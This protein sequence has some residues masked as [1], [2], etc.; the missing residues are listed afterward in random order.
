MAEQ[1]PLLPEIVP[2]EAPANGNGRK[3]PAGNG[4][5][6]YR[7]HKTL[8]RIARAHGV[9]VLES[10]LVATKAGDMTAAKL[11]LDRIWPAPRSAPASFSLRPTKTAADVREAMH[12]VLGRAAAGEITTADAQAFF[13]MLKDT[14]L[15]HTIDNARLPFDGAPA[16]V[17]DA[18]QMLADKLTKL[19]TA[20]TEPPAGE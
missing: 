18:R 3:A 7:R 19:L 11:I 6:G 17:T 16:K 14:Y 15:A 8:D 4:T 12:E 5:L 2:P 10:V 9:A 13:T 1:S 20:K